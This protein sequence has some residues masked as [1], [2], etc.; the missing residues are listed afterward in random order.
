[1]KGLS[2]TICIGSYGGFYCKFSSV[3][4]RVCL[5]HIAFTLYFCDLED[6]I[7]TL[8][9]K[10]KRKAKKSPTN[11]SI[12]TV[13]F[14]DN[15]MYLIYRMSRDARKQVSVFRKKIKNGMEYALVDS[16]R[17]KASFRISNI[18]IATCNVKVFE[19]KVRTALL[20]LE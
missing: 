3:A 10:K 7:T 14:N 9:E 1:M 11:P 20:K 15:M 19:R 13:S 12:N 16:M 5:G 8:T 6:F 2:F 17:T 4:W 18:Q